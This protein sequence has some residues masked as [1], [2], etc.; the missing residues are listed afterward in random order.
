MTS[1]TAKTITYD[2]FLSYSSKDRSDVQEVFEALERNGLRVFDLAARQ[3]EIWGQSIEETIST[4]L[5]ESRGAVVFISSRSNESEWCKSEWDHIKR[6]ATDEFRKICVLPVLLDSSPIPAFLENTVF[7]ERSRLTAA[8]IADAVKSRLDKFEL[9][10]QQSVESLNDAELMH[11]VAETRDQRAFSVLVERYQQPL[12][13][14]VRM[15]N[16]SDGYYLAEEIVC[17]V[18]VRVWEHSEKF[19]GEHGQFRAWLYGIARHVTLDYLRRRQASK[20]AQEIVAEHEETVDQLGD[21]SEVLSDLFS[22][23]SD[24]EQTILSMRYFSEHSTTEIASALGVSAATVRGRM[25][26]AM[27]RLRKA[28]DEYRLKAE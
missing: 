4:A 25:H 2:A 15:R 17:D 27:Q 28:F 24:E 11:R 19:S 20:H 3:A 18:W 16:R 6:Q 22:M 26:R 7:L 23:L 14:W 8:E 13:K 1:K 21:V 9:E 10:E 5:A 12:T